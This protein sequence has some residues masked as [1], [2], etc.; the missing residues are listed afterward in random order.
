MSFQNSVASALVGLTRQEREDIH[1]SVFFANTDPNEHPVYEELWLH[2]V[3]DSIYTQSQENETQFAHLQALENDHNYY[4]KGVFDYSY[5]LAHCHATRAPYI[6]MFE[7]DILL[8]DG[9]LVQTLKSLGEVHSKLKKS[10]W[11][12]LYMRLFNQERSTGWSSKRIGANHEHW[13][14]LGIIVEFLFVI[15]LLKRRMPQSLRAYLDA[16]T[17]S[18][19]CI[20]VIPSLVVLFFQSGKASILPPKPGVFAQNYGCC[21]QALLYPREQVPG[22]IEFLHEEVEGQVD[23]LVNIHAKREKLTRLS[24]YPVQVQHVG[25]VSL[26]LCQ[27]I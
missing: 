4:E 22:L 16:W 11:D 21:S 13:I 2:T 3:V 24:M 6:L 9:W 18:V 8:A 26:P 17:L 5:G 25:M 14:S 20:L 23:L 12:W 7:G 10:K 19:V 1:L 27:I 15:C